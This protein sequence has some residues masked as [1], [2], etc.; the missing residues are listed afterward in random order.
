MRTVTLG[1]SSVEETK[2]RMAAAFG[3]EAQGEVIS[4]ASVDLLWRVLTAKH[5]E[6]LC[7][8]TGQGELP[9]REVARRVGGDVKAVHREVTA[10]I[11]AGVLDR[12][13]G[14]VVFPYDAVHVDFT[15]RKAA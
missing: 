14:G 13:P 12:A 5:W 2:R 6:I 7:A 4:F 10:L 1:V 15:L 9:F 3:G 8:M 11:D